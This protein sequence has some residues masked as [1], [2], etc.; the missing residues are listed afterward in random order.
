M[1]ARRGGLLPAPFGRAPIAMV[2]ARDVAACAVAALTKDDDALHGTAWHL[3]GPRGVTFGEIAAALGARYV[4]V[5][6]RLA[7]RALRRRGASLYEVDHALRMAAYFAS[8]ADS[9]PTGAVARVSGAP[10]RD[11]EAYLAETFPS[12]PRAS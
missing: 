1:V 3:T 12:P 5:P 10:P 9:A 4:P 2:D 8:G 11:V 7:G 6:S